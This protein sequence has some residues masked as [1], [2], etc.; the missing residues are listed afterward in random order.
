MDDAMN[1]S[2]S[3]ICVRC[4]KG[5][6]GA[7]VCPNCGGSD[8]RSEDRGARILWRLVLL[9]VVAGLV[10]AVLGIVGF[11]EMQERAVKAKKAAATE[12]ITRGRELVSAGDHEGARETYGEATRSSPEDPVAWANLGAAESLLGNEI[13]AR[14]AYERVL[15]LD[16]EHWLAHYNLAL[17][18]A[19]AG[20]EE[21]ACEH[22]RR[23]LHNL[24]QAEAPQ[25]P[26]VLA[27]LEREAAFEKLR[28]DPACRVA[29]E[30]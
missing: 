8:W 6:S 3:R 16:P 19:R 22:L 13:E 14:K 27:D 4:G 2:D 11:R 12:Q 28:E 15:T 30:P 17:L 7:D 20:R 24:R 23:S 29:E 25:L 18:E 5:Y 9:A 21:A 10:V 26:A 1:P